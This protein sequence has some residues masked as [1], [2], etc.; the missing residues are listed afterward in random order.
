MLENVPQWM[1][2]SF[3]YLVYTGAVG[4]VVGVFFELVH[5]W[6]RLRDPKR[7]AVDG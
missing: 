1:A 4:I 7:S 6:K 5:R 3:P 2:D